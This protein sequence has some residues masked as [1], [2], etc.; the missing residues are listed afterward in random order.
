MTRL[1]SIAIRPPT[2][3]SLSRALGF[4][5]LPRS[6]GAAARG[7]SS[8]RLAGRSG[9]FGSL[10]VGV[11]P[12]QLFFDRPLVMRS[13]DAASRSALSRAGG[14]VRK[15]ARNSMRPSAVP[16]RQP[17]GR[18]YVRD[19]DGQIVYDRR[20]VWRKVEGGLIRYPAPSK[21]GEPPNRHSN[22]LLH[23]FTFYAFDPAS[24]SVVVGPSRLGRSTAPEVLEYGGSAVSETPVFDPKKKTWRRARRRVYV[25]ARPFMRPALARAIAAGV[26]PGYYRNAMRRRAA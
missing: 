1:A 12:K 21:P 14:Y 7:L 22:P 6:P 16:R 4:G 9:G 25:P 17:G 11:I 2:P 18:R 13:M 10:G 8:S 15:T 20:F 26:V 19:A 24:R 3:G 5:L 23:R